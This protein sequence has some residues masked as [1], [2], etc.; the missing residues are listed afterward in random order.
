MASWLVYPERS[1]RVGLFSGA[2]LTNRLASQVTQTLEV[3]QLPDS[4]SLTPKVA[5][6]LMVGSGRQLCRS[7][8]RLFLRLVMSQKEVRSVAT[9]QKFFDKDSIMSF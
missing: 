4:Q 6:S 5:N 9:G 1:R 7:P 3:P 2:W 8:Q